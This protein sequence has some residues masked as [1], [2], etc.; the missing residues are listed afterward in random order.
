MRKIA[1]ILAMAFA[2][3]V[4]V[5]VAQKGVNVVS[6]N[7]K[8]EK[9]DADAEHVK[10]GLR[11][12]TWVSRGNAYF[13]SVTI[14]TRDLFVGLESQLLQMKLGA[15]KSQTNEVVNGKEYTVLEYN[16]FKVYLAANKVVAWKVTSEIRN[17]ATDEALKSYAKALQLESSTSGSVRNALETMSNHYKQLGNVSMAIGDTKS[18]A[19][20]FLIVN[21]VQQNPGYGKVEPSILFLA[22]YMLTADGANNVSSFVRGEKALADALEAG[23]SAIDDADAQTPA[24]SKGNIYYYLFHCAYG[25]RLSNAAKLQDAKKYLLEG[26]KKYPLNQNIFEGLLTLY[27]SEEGLGD[28]TELLAPIEAKI[29]KDKNDS[30]AW[31]SRGRIYNALKDTDEC[32][33][34]FKMVAQI[35][36]NSFDGNYFLGIFYIQKGDEMLN[37][38][39]TTTYTDRSKS[40]EDLAAMNAVYAMAIPAFEAAHKLKPK[41]ANTLEMLKSLCFRLRDEEGIMDKYTKYNDLLKSL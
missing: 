4:G 38:F 24:E 36:P 17:D 41:D 23:Y 6:I 2:V 19:D 8:I 5:A 35:D 12:S 1:L 26:N 16:Y 22:G 39:N 25:Q 11:G 20:Y 9:A 29:A 21:K 40:E 34:S 18:A 32:I 30:G 14:P 3:N 28:P 37:E 15:P 10:K 13:E 7:S 33:A 27:T 31:F